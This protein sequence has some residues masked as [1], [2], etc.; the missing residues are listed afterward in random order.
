MNKFLLVPLV[1]A[2]S[3]ASLFAGAG[4]GPWALGAYYP[5]QLDG[6]YQ[7]SVSGNNITGVVGFAIVNGGLPFAS[8]SSAAGG[9]TTTGGGATTGTSAAS[10]NT[11]L[12]GVDETQNYFAI[13]VEGRTYT[14]R[15]VGMIDINRKKVTGTLIG[16]QP[17][18]SYQEL[19]IGQALVV[20]TPPD[21]EV[22]TSETV[23]PIAD[24]LP[25]LNR[26]LSG[27]FTANLK[28]TKNLMTFKG[29]GELATPAQKQ[30]ITADPSTFP[31]PAL[32]PARPDIII[33]GFTP[34]ATSATI[35][36]DT[37]C[38]N[39]Y[40]I[41]TSILATDPLASAG[42]AATGAN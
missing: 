42:T 12:V 40:G 7:A 32:D 4:T 22:V 8:R 34:R 24:N 2:L 36:T 1:T 14:G 21:Q 19:T 3:S 30:T 37:V 38:F 10:V 11:D 17:P 39:V 18:F 15:T 27:G 6:K 31:V 9:G 23:V 20:G 33:S 28:N 16:L 35:E 5:G 13:F 29:T 41:K 25:L 26:G